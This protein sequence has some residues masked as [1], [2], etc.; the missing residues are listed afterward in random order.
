MDVE[1]IAGEVEAEL[2]PKVFNMLLFISLHCGIKASLLLLRA[3]NGQMTPRR[4]RTN[5]PVY[6]CNILSRY[7]I[8]K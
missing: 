4:I 3:R 8:E 7:I 5:I 1:V 2:K 6:I